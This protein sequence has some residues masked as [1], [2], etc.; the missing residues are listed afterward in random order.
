M[1]RFRRGTRSVSIDRHANRVAMGVRVFCAVALLGV[2][3]RVAQLQMFPGEDLR[4][5]IDARTSGSR[6]RSA[7][8]CSTGAAGCSP[9]PAWATAW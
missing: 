6:I 2:G 7:A 1:A 8:I 3:T 4:T 5:A 9:R